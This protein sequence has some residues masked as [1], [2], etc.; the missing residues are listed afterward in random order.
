[1]IKPY[2]V[3]YIIRSGLRI[4]FCQRD[5]VWAHSA[6]SWNQDFTITD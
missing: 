6:C 3:Q 5:L 1:M 2:S 4:L